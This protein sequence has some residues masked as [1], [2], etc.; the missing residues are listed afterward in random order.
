[1]LDWP[2]SA[3]LSAAEQATPDM[4]S[5]DRL[6]WINMATP[7]EGGSAVPHPACVL[8]GDRCERW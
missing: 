7:G 1:M 2:T 6:T 5:D 3:R 8:A 4:R